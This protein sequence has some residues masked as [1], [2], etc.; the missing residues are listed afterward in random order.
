[1]I[2]K[3]TLRHFGCPKFSATLGPSRRR[4]VCGEI[5]TSHPTSPYFTLLHPTS[6]ADMSHHQGYQDYLD[7]QQQG[8]GRDIG[9]T[10]AEAAF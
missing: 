9:P 8:I 2:S 5:C 1:M 7:D 3:A 10:E 4:E 6:P